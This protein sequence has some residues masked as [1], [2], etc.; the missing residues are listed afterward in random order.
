LYDTPRPART[1]RAARPRTTPSAAGWIALAIWAGLAIV[2]FLACVGVVGA[3]SRMT[4]GLPPVSDLDK[5]TFSEQSIVYD[6]TGKVELARFGGER[7][8]VV[9]FKDIPPIVI[10]AQTAVE[11]KTFWDNAGFDPLAIVAAGLD[12]LRGSS[13]GASTITQQLVR[14]RLLDPAL[15][16]DPHRTFE[17]KIKEIIQSIRL[18]EA[19]PG[20]AGKQQ[21]IA[22][23][24]NQNYYGNQAY[25]V[26][27]AAKA[28]FG[29]DDLFKLTPAQAAILA[30]LPKSPSNY[31]L[32][33]NASVVCDPISPQDT[34]DTCASGKSNLVVD[35]NSAIVQRRNQILELLANGRTTIS[36]NQ[37]T[38]QQLR[39]AENDEVVLAPQVTPPWVAPHFVWAVQQELADK[40]C[41]GEATC[42]ALEQ[43]GLTIT[44]T[45]DVRLQAIAEKWVQA[46]AIVPNSKNPAALAKSLKL[47]YA[48][49]MR[50]LRGKDV[51]NGAM[52]ALDYQTGELVAYV[53]SANY[54]ATKATKQFQ[55]KFDV[56]GSGFR[57]PGSAFKPFNYLTGIDDKKMTAASMFMDTSTN[58]GGNYTPAD[59]DN[60]ER[61][62][63]RV[64]NAL[65]FSLN[66]PAV[67]AALVN[68]PDHLFARAQDYG[69]V[70]QTDKATAGASIALGVQEV[71]PVD[72]VTAYGTLANGGKKIGHTTILSVK[73]QTGKDAIPPYQPPAGDQVASPQ[74][75]FIVTDILAGNTDPNV[76]PFWG[77][78]EITGPGGKHRPATL[79]TGTNNDAKDLNAYG[80]I[81]APTDKNRTAGNYA[82]AV[83]AWVGNSDNTVISTPA[84]PVFSIDVTTFMWQGFMQ[85]ATAKWPI[86]DFA[87]PSG[88]TQAKVD[89]FTGM[90]PSAGGK[91]ITEWFIPGTEPKAAVPADMCGGDVLR[92]DTVW[93]G[94]FPNWLAADENWINRAERGPGVAGGVNRSPTAYFYNGLFRPFGN[95]WGA[96]VSGHG[97]AAPS[98]SVTCYPVPTAD[99]STGIVP[100]FAIPSADPSANILFEPCAP[101]SVVPSASPSEEASVPPSEPPP[102]EPPAP[103]PT[104]TP[105]PT[106]PPTPAPT[107]TPAPSEAV[108]AAS[109]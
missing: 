90:R 99:P 62:P 86:A 101:P 8:T 18:T 58:F 26:K 56:V 25:G 104:P 35:P 108:P 102:T 32:V 3:F 54:Y 13:R 97:C 12:S 5:I 34:E 106:P 14:Q 76:N 109:G 33:K 17:R 78:F 69:M 96:L 72:L 1:A 79:K 91:S 61:G 107:P 6:R 2:A 24:L 11:D 100:S 19:Y 44:T 89:P 52:V 77:K 50:N 16:S 84:R 23:Y 87:V 40:L 37:Y 30:G 36:G 85:D 60:L 103:T 75:S 15:V 68:G 88:L 105:A 93:E 67:K 41:D 82:L 10:D 71:R 64:R 65:Q 51:H 28:Y 55:P 57:Q 73:D 29:V 66:I 4:E 74:A 43:G 21:I 92:L 20:Q 9:P 45:L 22:D 94:H 47:P 83:G 38:P 46:A 81:A 63:V 53:G 49:W 31:D 70:F 39:D 95:S 27:A 7:R 98:P 42:T 59:A 48:Q 80:Y